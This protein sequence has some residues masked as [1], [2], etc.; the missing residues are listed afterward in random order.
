LS[1]ESLKY[2]ISGEQQDIAAGIEEKWQS[3]RCRFEVQVCDSEWTL[4][5]ARCSM[6]MTV[7]EAMTINLMAESS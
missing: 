2:L 5:A 3:G 4:A 1:D 7:F 6:T